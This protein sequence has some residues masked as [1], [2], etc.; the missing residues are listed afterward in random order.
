[1][2]R[3]PNCHQ[4]YS[5]GVTMCPHDGQALI[6]SFDPM[7]GK[8]LEGKYRLESCIGVGGMATVYLAT[9]TQIGDSVAV[10]ILNEESLKN[11]LAVAR[12]RREAQAAARIH[13]NSVVT[14]HDMG[15]LPEG[16]T[17]LVMEYIKGHSLRDELKE[18]KTLSVPRAITLMSAVCNAVHAAHDAGIIHRDLKPENIMV[19][20]FSDDSE[21]VKVVDFGVAELREHV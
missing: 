15:N 1:M 10:K 7:L 17:F 3:C 20:K 19:Q 14:I 21:T 6:P 8:L 16:N 4:E 9:R 13:H 5:D 18:Q 2:K 11:P 12:F